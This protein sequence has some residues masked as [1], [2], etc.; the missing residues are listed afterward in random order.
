MATPF[1]AEIRIFAGQSAPANWALCNGQ[2]MPISQNT[3]LFSLI[4]TFYG[5]DG[6]SNF[7][8]PNLQGCV[9]LQTNDTYPIGEIEGTTTVT[10]TQDEMPA[11]NHNF[12]LFN[13]QA[14]LQ[15]PTPTYALAKPDGATP[16]VPGSPAPPVVTMAATSLSP[17]G[18]GFPHN[19][20]MPF[21]TVTFCIALQGIFP[22]LN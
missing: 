3:A 9:P 17:T 19:N 21:L 6:K 10:L 15:Q 4:G 7:G 11:H 13:Q 18:S 8:L 22:R 20:M 14:D 1:L 5:G 12:A 16:F 2:I